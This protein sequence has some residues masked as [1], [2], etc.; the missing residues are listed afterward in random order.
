MLSEAVLALAVPG[1]LPANVTQTGR[2][3]SRVGKKI[4]AAHFG[5]AVLKQFKHLALE[6]DTSTHGSNAVASVSSAL[7]RR[8]RNE[9]IVVKSI[10]VRCYGYQLGAAQDECLISKGSAKLHS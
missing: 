10:I 5:P 4:V 6:R 9:E 7:L 2:G 1:G 8:P 3:S